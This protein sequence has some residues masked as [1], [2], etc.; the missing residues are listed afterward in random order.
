M[1]A[2]HVIFVNLGSEVRTI[3]L[4]PGLY[5]SYDTAKAL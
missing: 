1:L 2:F 4:I 3:S 5:V